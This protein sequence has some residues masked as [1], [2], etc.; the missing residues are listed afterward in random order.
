MICGVKRDGRG[1]E[2]FH[3]H[4]FFW[5]KMRD[6]WLYLGWGLLGV[7]AGG[8]QWLHCHHSRGVALGAL[9]LQGLLGRGGFALQRLQAHLGFGWNGG[10][11]RNDPALGI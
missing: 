5:G 10:K 3:F 7:P 9:P 6:L 8:T 2:Y 4:G 1:A 11:R